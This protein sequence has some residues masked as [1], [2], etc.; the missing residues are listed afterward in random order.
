MSKF[1]DANFRKQL[2]TIF[3]RLAEKI[4]QDEQFA[5]WI[6]EGI[7][8]SKRKNSQGKRAVQMEVKS[9]VS[10]AIPL[11]DIF[12]IFSTGGPEGLRDQLNTYE[13]EI[14]IDIVLNNGLDPVRKVR[15]WKTKK[16]IIT[17]IVD[18]ISKQMSKGNTFLDK[19]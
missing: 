13:V 16:K 15:K 18:V 14:L 12:A 4:E 8:F 2:S 10:E 19:G 6:F 7:N 9:V 1:S 11:P 5:K 3:I 17:Y